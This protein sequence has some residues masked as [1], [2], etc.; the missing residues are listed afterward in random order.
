MTIKHLASLSPSTRILL[1]ISLLLVSIVFIAGAARAEAASQHL[2][3]I[4]EGDS[5]RSIISNKETLREAFADA[6]IAIDPADK[7][8]PNVDKKLVSNDYQVNIYR[9]RPITIVDGV[10]QIRVMTA[11]QTPSQIARQASVELRSE[12][13]TQLAFPDDVVADGASLRLTIDR[14]LPVQL[15]LYGKSE[16][17]YTQATTVKDF[18]R[19]K[20]I[21]LTKDDRVSV[22]QATNIIANMQLRVW[23]EGKQTVT[24]DEPIAPPTETV[25]DANQPIG[26]KKVQDEGKPG[27]KSVTYE[28]IVING[29]EVSRQAIQSVDIE[30]PTKQ[31]VIVGIK[32]NGSGLSKA[33][34]VYTYVDS[35]GVSHRET[36]YDL[37]M[38]SV[39]GNCGAGGIYSVRADGAKVDAAGNIIIAANLGRYPRCSI[40]ETSLGPGKVYDTGGFAAKHPDGFDLAT[41]WSNYDGI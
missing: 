20:S 13:K 2:I 23:R 32:P 15:D 3:T 36:Y 19:E 29:Q 38:K 33:K 18:L 34:G 31:I 22:D 39:M 5:V 10:H 41:D 9:A 21:T 14:A 6:G 17:V 12:D 37:P 4:H 25:Q 30:Q 40:V 28:L 1:F 24:V 16:V 7:I 26:Y 27:R 11:Y 35:K 8:E